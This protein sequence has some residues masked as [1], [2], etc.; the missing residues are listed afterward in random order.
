MNSQTHANL[1]FSE[2][3]KFRDVATL[4]ILPPLV[5]SVYYPND[6]KGKPVEFLTSLPPP[7]AWIIMD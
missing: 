7:S 3:I 4:E 1:F 2:N 6:W 5:D